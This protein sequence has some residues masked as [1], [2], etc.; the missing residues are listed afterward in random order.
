MPQLL[1]TSFSQQRHNGIAY[2]T[3]DIENRVISGMRRKANHYRSRKHK[4]SQDPVRVL[5]PASSAV[6]GDGGHFCSL[7]TP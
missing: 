3:C 4:T 6:E 7:S 2:R 5:K 1:R